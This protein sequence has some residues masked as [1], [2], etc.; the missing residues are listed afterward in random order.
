M[1]CLPRVHAAAPQGQD[2]RSQAASCA[3]RAQRAAPTLQS[4]PGVFLGMHLQRSRLS[5]FISLQ[6]WS[7]SSGAL[8]R[9]KR[10]KA[11]TAGPP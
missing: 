6:M 3:G 5:S 8:P 7:L 1:A 11:D 2:Q 4:A 9:M 10:W